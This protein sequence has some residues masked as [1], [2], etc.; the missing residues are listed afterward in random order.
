MARYEERAAEDLLT[1]Q[2]IVEQL[3]AWLAG[4]YQ[5]AE[6]YLLALIA[7]RVR[8]DLNVDDPARRA[9]AITR[10]R[11]AARDA[12]AQIDTEQAA[13]RLVD[14]AMREGTAAAIEQLDVVAAASGATGPAMFAGEVLPFATGLTP[15]AAL[16][17]ATIGLELTNALTVMEDRILRAVPDLYQQVIA[18]FA[19]EQILTGATRR[20]THTRAIAEFLSR[21]VTGFT[22]AAGRRWTVGSYA[23]MAAR[24]AT[25][26]AWLDSHRHAWA[27]RGFEYVTIVRGSDSCQACAAWSG[28]ILASG[29]GRT[30]QVETRHATTGRPITIDVVGTLADAR[31][32]GW[33]HPNCRCTLAPVFAGLSLPANDS[34]Y[35]P[36]S[37]RNRERLRYLERRVRKFKREQQIAQG[38]GDDV[39]AKG[40]G[41]RVRAEQKRI[42]ELVDETGQIRKPYREQLA[43]SDGGRTPDRTR[44]TPVN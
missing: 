27:A 6:T 33:N 43:Y 32:A 12:L 35:D 23:E 22:D 7:D 14:T 34:T 15:Q 39:A 19:G 16:T 36:Q 41:R 25:N 11:A 2:E 1:G 40:F 10:L 42:R 26:R 17:A 13:R 8:R 5:Q 24:T 4:Q 31:A 28:R 44:P 38:L 20:T 21:G 18:R 29:G 9:A 37:E 3:G 30:G